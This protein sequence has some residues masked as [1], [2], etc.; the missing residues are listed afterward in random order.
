MKNMFKVFFEKIK[1]VFLFF[2]GKRCFIVSYMS[3]SCGYIG[4]IECYGKSSNSVRQTFQKN[5]KNFIVL[6]I[7]KS[8]S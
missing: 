8:F 6:E 2:I 7:S 5:F 1:T 3:K 4:K